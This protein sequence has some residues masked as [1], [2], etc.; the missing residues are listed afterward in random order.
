[1]INSLRIRF[2][3]EVLNVR[4]SKFILIAA[5]LF[6]I[7]CLT[8]IIALAQSQSSNEVTMINFSFQPNALIVPAGTTVTWTNDDPTN[9][10]VT[11]D[12]GTFD[13]GNIISGGQFSYLFDSPG[14]YSYYCSIHT[15]MHGTILVTSGSASSAV[16][17]SYS[18]GLA[19]AQN[20]VSQYS[21]YF[22]I[23]TGPTPKVHITAPQKY[24]T[25]GKVPTSLYFS[26][27]NQAASYSQYQT[28]ATYSGGNTLWIQG[29]TTWTQ[30]AAVPL[31][32]SL[33]LLAVS[34]TGGNGY[35][36]EVYPYGNLIKNYYYFY[37]Y[38]TIGFYA[39]SVGQHI[40]LFAIDDQVSNAI[41][42][43]VVG[44]YPQGYQQPNYQPPSYQQSSSY[45]PPGYG[46]PSYPSSGGSSSVGY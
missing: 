12:D 23:V 24:D 28:Y 4:M 5:L 32:S 11:S 3:E 34:P 10:T 37:P 33:S 40:L 19:A 22:Q 20:A 46:Q 2:N 14:N 15:Y 7:A 36:F 45:Q 26:G 38:N 13:S 18:D 41:V 39:D 29:A 43:D 17:S 16:S 6:I 9:H 35:L 27:Q 21:Q 44:N 30:Y 42:I 25:S 8:G 31:G 1:M